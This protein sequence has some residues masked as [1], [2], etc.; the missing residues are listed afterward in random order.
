[1]L[2]ASSLA[3]WFPAGQCSAEVYSQPLP[4]YF[5]DLVA[6]FTACPCC[7]GR[8]CRGQPMP[9]Q[10]ALHVGQGLQEG[11][12]GGQLLQRMGEVHIRKQPAKGREH[13]I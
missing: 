3:N 1:M 7:V 9:R 5:D 11:A 4:A 13:E 6:D 10:H 12:L 8:Q 2:Q